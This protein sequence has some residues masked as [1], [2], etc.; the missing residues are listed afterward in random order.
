[1]RLPVRIGLTQSNLHRAEEYLLDI[2]HPKSP[3]YG[4]FWTS[5]DVIAAFQPSENAVQAIR[6]WLASHDI[7]DVTHSDNKGWLAFDAPA[8]TV[9]KLMKAEFYEHEDKVTGGVIP[10]CDKYHV[11]AKVQEHIDYITPGTKLMA[12][13]TGDTDLVQKR[14]EKAP[15]RFKFGQS[16]RHDIDAEV[17]DM[18]LQDVNSLTTC[19]VAITPACVAALYNITSGTLAS[20]NNSLGIFESEL[21][22]WDQ[23]DLDLF[24]ANFS[25]DIPVGTHPLNEDVDGG[26][27][28]TNR[29]ALAGGESMLDLLLAYPIIYPQTITVLNVDDLHYQTWENDTYTVS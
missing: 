20:P 18:I 5:E 26:V 16:V 7:T 15:R 29:T 3:N 9:E 28:Q 25:T 24:F 8:S 22:F 11:P 19:D 2:S 13:V 27:A 14:G 6:D 12:P 21:Q 17:K 4:K 10:A 23:E 1:M